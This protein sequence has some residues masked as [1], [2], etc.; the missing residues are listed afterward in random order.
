MSERLRAVAIAP[1]WA[2]CAGGAVLVWAGHALVR[3]IP[4][5]SLAVLPRSPA[6]ASR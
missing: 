1:L 6:P 4:H 3:A 5:P 2:A